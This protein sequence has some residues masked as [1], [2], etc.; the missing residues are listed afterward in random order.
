MLFFQLTLS[1]ALDAQIATP[2]I[3]N[4]DTKTLNAA[5]GNFKLNNFILNWSFGEVFSTTLSKSDKLILTTDFLQSS[6]IEI[7]LIPPDDT[8][9]QDDSIQLSIKVFPNPAALFLYLTID[10]T[11]VKLLTIGLYNTQGN[12]LF[13]VDE[14]LNTT[15]LY[16]RTIPV[17]QYTPGV[18]LL[19]IKYVFGKT[20]YRTKVFKIIKV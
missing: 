9:L 4:I 19:A 1:I 3:S 20:H 14:I 7:I 13:S 16:N 6:N 12:L 8:I 5:G 17:N 10:Q 2:A 11:K 18:Y 15:N